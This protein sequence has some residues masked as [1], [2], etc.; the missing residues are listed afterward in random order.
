MLALFGGGFVLLRARGSSNATL[1]VL[2]GMVLVL[3]IR[4]LLLVVIEAARIR[5][6][7]SAS[8]L[9]AL[10]VGAVLVWIVP[11]YSLPLVAILVLALTGSVWWLVSSLIVY[12]AVPTFPTWVWWVVFVCMF[13][14]A[15]VMTICCGQR[16]RPVTAFVFGLATIVLTVGWFVHV[17]VVSAT[18]VPPAGPRSDYVYLLGTN[19]GYITQFL[20]RSLQCFSPATGTAS[21]TVPFLTWPPSNQ[22]DTAVVLSVVPYTTSSWACYAQYIAAGTATIIGGLACLLGERGNC[23]QILRV[24]V[25]GSCCVWCSDACGRCRHG[26]ARRCRCCKCCRGRRGITAVG[27]VAPVATA[28]PVQH[29]RPRRDSRSSGGL[30]VQFTPLLVSEPTQ[31]PPRA[32]IGALQQLQRLQRHRDSNTTRIHRDE[33]HAD[34]RPLLR[35]EQRQSERDVIAGDVAGD[36]ARDAAGDAA[37]AQAV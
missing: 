28:T 8:W 11:K 13:G 9:L 17:A 36:V 26:C 7:E 4:A 10:L 20:G 31:P 37:A 6:A 15:M 12:A 30:H 14:V 34:T 23:T 2:V 32:D 19:M 29:R 22:N 18:F 5:N 21:Y 27:A 25:C 35:P 24:A 33:R 1:R 16:L 3:V